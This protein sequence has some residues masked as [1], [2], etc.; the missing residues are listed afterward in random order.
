[1]KE[2]M[3]FIA[4]VSVALAGCSNSDSGSSGAGNA[5]SSTGSVSD[6]S[7][8]SSSA[9]M[10]NQSPDPDL[11][12]SGEDASSFNN[13][14]DLSALAF[15]RDVGA[16]ENL[17]IAS[18]SS[19]VTYLAAASIDEVDGEISNPQEFPEDF[20]IINF[21]DYGISMKVTLDGQEYSYTGTC[22]GQTGVPVVCDNLLFDLTNRTLAV[23]D[24]VVQAIPDGSEEP[25]NAATGS[26]V[27]SGII[28]WTEDDES[29][30]E[31]APPA[32]EDDSL[33]GSPATLAQLQG[34]WDIGEGGDEIYLAVDGNTFAEYDYDGD[35]FDM[36][37]NCYF[38]DTGIIEA[39]GEGRFRITNDFDEQQEIIIH[40]QED[41]LVFSWGQGSKVNRS[42]SDF[43]PEC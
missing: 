24:F 11:L 14:F 34:V 41:Q 31:K 35:A 26:L 23:L 8:T 30:T 4:L 40:F 10:V 28:Q 18:D 36:G 19:A 39:L 9:E 5:Y 38:I 42:V 21:M 33:A 15:R 29:P 12:V 22:A 43:V 27:L 1:M 25:D 2:S 20:V 13:R 3:I 16:S 32:V 7:S 17:L 6:S 37:E